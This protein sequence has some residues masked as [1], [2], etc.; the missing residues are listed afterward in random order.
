MVLIR[1]LSSRTL[2]ASSFVSGLINIVLVLT[3][4]MAVGC[5]STNAYQ[6]VTAG[7]CLQELQI[8]EKQLGQIRHSLQ[9]M[10]QWN[11][12]WTY[13]DETSKSRY[14]KQIGKKLSMVL[15]SLKRGLVVH[16]PTL[17]DAVVVF[18]KSTDG[19][20]S[21]PDLVHSGPGFVGSFDGDKVA[22]MATAMGPSWRF[23]R[24][25]G[26][27]IHRDTDHSPA[28]VSDDE[29]K[30]HLERYREAIKYCE[31]ESELSLLPLTIPDYAPMDA[32]KEAVL[33]AIIEA[34]TEQAKTMFTKDERLSITVP[35]FNVSDERIWILLEE[36]AGEAYTIALNME[37]LNT[38]VS[39][40]YGGTVE[41]KSNPRNGIR[42]GAE[43]KIKRGAIKAMEYTIP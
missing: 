9:K 29:L 18:R 37:V 25:A 22:A 21:N 36:T 10:F 15:Y 14:K 28:L 17:E 27:D 23:L 30:R 41:I 4:I 8:G 31:T 20:I 43:E 11:A 32:R 35:N 7:E 40:T 12:Y 3:S 34:T 16:V 6:P 13:N 42:I 33:S 5:W 2:V 24:L 26:L 38:E 39:V 19:S 1:E